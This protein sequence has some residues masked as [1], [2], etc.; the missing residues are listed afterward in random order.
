MVFV[1]LKYRQAYTEMVTHSVYG[2]RSDPVQP[3]TEGLR[4]NNKI[5]QSIPMDGDYSHGFPILPSQPTAPNLHSPSD[6]PSVPS[7]SHEQSD[8]DFPMAITSL[9]NLPGPRTPSPHLPLAGPSRIPATP[10]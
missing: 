7:S 6:V 2:A 10:T 5:F 9:S 8:L 3:W 4:Q 1:T